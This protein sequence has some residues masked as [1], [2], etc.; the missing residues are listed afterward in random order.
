MLD[1]EDKFSAMDQRL[2]S[3]QEYFSGLIIKYGNWRAKQE[4]FYHIHHVEKYYEAADEV[5]KAREELDNAI[6]KLIVAA[7]KN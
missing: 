7:S 6:T 2:A 1:Y 4:E 3:M 5:E